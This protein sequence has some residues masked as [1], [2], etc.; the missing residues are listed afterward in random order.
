MD[1]L[2]MQGDTFKFWNGEVAAIHPAFFTA[3]RP[4]PN[5]IRWMTPYHLGALFVLRKKL[6]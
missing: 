6:V 5:G 3:F 2:G 4:G 1:A